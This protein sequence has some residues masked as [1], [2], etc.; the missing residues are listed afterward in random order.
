MS[1]CRERRPQTAEP[2]APLEVHATDIQARVA[3]NIHHLLPACSDRHLEFKDGLK[4]KHVLV[5]YIA[6]EHE[7][8]DIKKTA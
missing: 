1:R 5:L 4:L 2:K 6:T 7:H 8:E 3:L